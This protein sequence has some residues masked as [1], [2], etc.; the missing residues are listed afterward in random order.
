MAL[1]FCSE[2]L[3]MLMQSSSVW[4][5]V[6][7]VVV[8]LL[9]CTLHSHQWQHITVENSLLNLLQASPTIVHVTYCSFSIM[10]LPTGPPPPLHSSTT[11]WAPAFVFILLPCSWSAA[12]W[13]EWRQPCFWRNKQQQITA[14]HNYN[15]VL[16][17]S[18]TVWDKLHHF[19]CA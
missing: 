11:F 13:V 8:D 9:C 3:S 4:M 14:E 16:Y 19:L 12:W 1:T 17:W 6:V 18:S 7:V 5:V 10:L 2:F 15:L